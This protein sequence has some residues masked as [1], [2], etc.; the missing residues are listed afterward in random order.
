MRTT[1]DLDEDVLM[2]VKDLAK[3]RH[4]S[5]GRVVSDL[6]RRALVYSHTAAG[7][8]RVMVAQEPAVTNGKSLSDFGIHPF[9]YEGGEIP[10]NELVNRLREEEGI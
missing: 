7:S 6:T 10:T 8:A 1:I 9:P 5:I 2:A 3:Y 4:E